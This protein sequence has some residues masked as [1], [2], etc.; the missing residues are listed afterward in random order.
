MAYDPEIPPSLIAQGIGGTTG[1][2]W[3]GLMWVDPIATVLTPGY[4]S[5]AEELGMRPGDGLIYKDTNR[6][7]W[8]H[9]DL[10]VDSIDGTGAATVKFPEIPEEAMSLVASIDVDV[11]EA[12]AVIYLNGRQVRTPIAEAANAIIKFAPLADYDALRDYAGAATWAR[13]MGVLGSAAD[14]KVG[15]FY[16]TT[17]VATA[18]DG[19]TVIVADNGVRWKRVIPDGW[20]KT[21]WF[22]GDTIDEAF[23]AALSS[24]YNVEFTP[25]NY[26][27]AVGTAYLTP[28]YGTQL[29]AGGGPA[30]STSTTKRTVKITNPN[31][32]GGI[33]WNVASTSPNQLAAP[34]IEGFELVAD[35]PIKMNDP[36]VLVADGGGATSPFLMQGNVK[37]NTLRPR[38]NGT[39]IGIQMAKAFNFDIYQNNIEQFDINILLLGCD[40]GSVRLNRLTRGWSYH[41]LQL[42]AQTFG[43]QVEIANNDILQPGSAACV[44]IKTSNRQVRVVDNY[45][46]ATGALKGFIDISPTDSPTYGSNA[47]SV[48]FSIVCR[49]NR[50]DGMSL[51]TDFVYRLKPTAVHTEIHDVGTTGA[52]SAARGLVIEGDGLPVMFAGVNGCV[53]DFLGDRFRPY[54]AFRS[55][56]LSGEEG[57]PKI[58]AKTLANFVSALAAN[59]AYQ[60]MRIVD[61]AIGLLTTFQANVVSCLMALP[62]YTGVDNPWFRADAMYRIKIVA[63]TTSASGDTLRAGAYSEGVAGSLTSFACTTQNKAFYLY[64]PG[65]ADTV[66][67]GVYFARSTANG[68]LLIESIEFEEVLHGSKTMDFPSVA[69]GATTTTTVTV[70]GAAV[71][72]SLTAGLSV[73]LQGMVMTAYCSAAGTAT[74]VLYNPTAGAINLASAT[75]NVFGDKA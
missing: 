68:V 64:A 7:E 61:G 9:Y 44:F 72:D 42:S 18:D 62:R 30:F 20:V 17:D 51:T 56:A 58:T 11:D 29:R 35:F 8:D 13:I 48:T 70:L 66:P 47:Q 63:R 10:I 16:R 5:N 54:K 27:L 45:L 53:Y 50:I 23:Q 1:L 38:V 39:G 57:I 74:V 15:D 36:T 24:G 59:N 69:A 21:C 25:G 49:D 26:T 73:D 34:K 71:G 37:N 41:I 31:V 52:T 14:G 40:I 6:G 32:G 46:E 75:L 43:S 65:Q 55:E 67:T 22:E 4:I 12:F 60:H 3:F 2:R 19:G 28:S 33:F